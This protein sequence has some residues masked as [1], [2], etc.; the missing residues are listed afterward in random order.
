MQ[1][2]G[3]DAVMSAGADITMSKKKDATTGVMGLGTKEMADS[4]NGQIKAVLSDPATKNDFTTAFKQMIADANRVS[5]DWKNAVEP[6]EEFQGAEGVWKG[7]SGV[8]WSAETAKGKDF[9]ISP[10]L[11]MRRAGVK[12][13]ESKNKSSFL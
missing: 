13:F 5:D 12:S 11:F 9:S 10:F 2:V 7:D 8:N 1:E 4:L 6:P 3:L